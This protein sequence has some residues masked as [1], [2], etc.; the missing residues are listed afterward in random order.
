MPKTGIQVG[1][2]LQ[3][4][5]AFDTPEQLRIHGGHP[6][7]DESSIEY[8]FNSYG[9][10]CPEFDVTADIR[11]VTIGCS[12]TAG[13][14]LP[15]NALFHERFAARL[16]EDTGKS[17]VNWNLARGGYGIDIVERVLHLGVPLLD[18]HIVL[19]LF[20]EVGRREYLSP[21]GLHVTFAP[22]MVG[23]YAPAREFVDKN[24]FSRPDGALMKLIAHT[25]ADLESQQDNELRFFRTYKSIE[26]LLH[27]RC[28]LFGF[29]NDWIEDSYV[30]RHLDAARNVGVFPDLDLARDFSHPGPYSQ[31]VFCDEFWKAFERV[32]TRCDDEWTLG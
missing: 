4:W 21:E 10:R 1:A 31:Q 27:G 24:I 15:Q 18:P 8:R 19:V 23:S 22:S 3:W 2:V 30:A 6:L 32:R 20:P 7:Y 5:G 12:Y 29:V 17:V 26:A 11:M 13:E 25:L 16:A 28:W 14:G 9:Y